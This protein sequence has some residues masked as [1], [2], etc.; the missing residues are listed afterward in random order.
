MSDNVEI[1][2]VAPPTWT[3]PA[4]VLVTVLEG[5][6]TNEHAQAEIRRMNKEAR[7]SKITIPTEV[8]VQL[9]S[10]LAGWHVEESAL[11]NPWKEDDNG[12]Q[13]Y[14]EEAQDKFND[15]SGSVE[16]ILGR[17]F[18]KGSCSEREEMY[19]CN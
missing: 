3:W 5:N 16:E 14:T 2:D 19:E 12:D 7:T 13:S 11:D 9:Y 1:I 18:K 8:L 6:P 15:A 4:D 10:E 17:F